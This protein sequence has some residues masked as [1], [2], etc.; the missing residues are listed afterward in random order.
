MFTVDG[1]IGSGARGG[2]DDVPTPNTPL[3]FQELA[4]QCCFR[5]TLKQTC[6]SFS[7][8]NTEVCVFMCACVKV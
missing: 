2:E 6:D 8:I 1:G 3:R 4:V 5:A 7:K